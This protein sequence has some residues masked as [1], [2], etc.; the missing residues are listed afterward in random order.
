MRQIYILILASLIFK[1]ETCISQ[2][3]VDGGKTRHRFAQMNLGL[4]LRSFPGNS[5]GS[6]SVLPSG[7]LRTIGVDD[8]F[9]SRFIIG[10]THFWG[11]ADFFIAIPFASDGSGFS[12]S[13]ETGGRYF[14]WRIEHGKIRPFVGISMMP[15]I[16]QQGDGADLLKMTIP[17]S[18]GLVFNYKK[19]LFEA[20]V[21]YIPNPQDQYYIS[22]NLTTD[23]LTPDT[24]LS[25]GYKFM[26]ETTLS[27][28]RDWKSGRT[29]SLTDTLSKLNRLN[30][31]TLAIGPSASFFLRSSEHNSS[32]APFLYQHEIANVFP[33]FGVGYYFH[34]PDLQFNLAYRGIKSSIEAYGL[35]Q[36]AT[37]RALTLE[38][39]KF[40][41][42][43]HGFVPF[44]GPAISR[45][46]LEVS[47]RNSAGQAFSGSDEQLRFGLTFGWDIRPNRLQ[48]FYLRTNLRWFPSMSVPMS[49]GY[50]FSFDQLEFNFIQLVIFPDRFF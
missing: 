28:E 6:A 18:A 30:G 32:T 4:D 22:R 27:A 47:E 21:G 42:D 1:A 8:H 16:Y 40:I 9:E 37:R 41:F 14:P 33:E 24:W 10:G 50:E 15:G 20:T 19:H 17:L 44:V 34:R 35:E 43:Y 2:P 48:G 49:S 3:Y 5:S 12:S 46:W 7:G 39:Y 31:L 13:V 25:I 38:A 26:F 11:H 45:E 23:L 36:T 29:K